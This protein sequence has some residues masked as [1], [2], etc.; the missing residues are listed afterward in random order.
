MIPVSIATPPKYEYPAERPPNVWWGLIPR[1][2]ALFEDYLNRPVHVDTMRF[3]D[4]RFA[5]RLLGEANT[6]MREVASVYGFEREIAGWELRI[7]EGPCDEYGMPV[8]SFASS[9]TITVIAVDSAGV[10]HDI[11]ALAME[12]S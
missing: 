2:R 1:L 3:I 8:E 12:A 10:G 4:K 5:A 11:G 9:K 7:W 6:C